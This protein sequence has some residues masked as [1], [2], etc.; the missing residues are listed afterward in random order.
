M[1]QLKLVKAIVVLLL[2]VYCAVGSR[3][4]SWSVPSR[5]LP[6]ISL[7]VMRRARMH[8]GAL[9]QCALCGCWSGEPRYEQT[10][11]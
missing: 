11:Q 2:Q 9:D 4:V 7:L 3:V 5:A 1:L 10:A 6:L 8:P